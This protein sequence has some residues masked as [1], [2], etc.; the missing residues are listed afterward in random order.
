MPK[1]EQISCTLSTPAESAGLSTATEASAPRAAKFRKASSAEAVHVASEDFNAPRPKRQQEQQKQL[2]AKA[3]AST[4]GKG[5]AMLAAMG[6][7]HGSSLGQR[8]GGLQTP[9]EAKRRVQRAALCG[10]GEQKGGAHETLQSAVQL[11]QARLLELKPPQVHGPAQ[12]RALQWH[13]ELEKRWGDYRSCLENSGAF[14]VISCPGGTFCSFPRDGLTPDWEGALEGWLTHRYESASVKQR[15]KWRQAGDSARKL[16]QQCL[17][18]AKHTTNVIVAAEAVQKS[19][20]SCALGELSGV[21]EVRLSV[22]QGSAGLDLAAH[23][24]GFL[25]EGVDDVPGQPDGVE[26]GD[27]ILQIESQP[28]SGLDEAEMC[29]AFKNKVKDGASLLVATL[30]QMDE[31]DDDEEEHLAEAPWG[32][33]NH[34]GRA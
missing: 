29:G 21:R 4:Y 6:Y 11:I 34:P 28:L 15:T 24:F 2:D 17:A 1:R 8:A 32:S 14:V 30:A 16:L 20:Q 33:Q 7:K 3:L 10:V 31:A 13:G 27:V 26:V 5:F 18:R 22:Q 19:F 12:A 9:L 25:V 23:E